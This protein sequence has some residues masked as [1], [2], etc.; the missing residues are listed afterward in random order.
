MEDY[1]SLNKKNTERLINS[2]DEKKHN[3]LVKYRYTI[4]MNMF[5]RF[6][7]KDAS[8]L[9]IGIRDGAFLEFMR[10]HGYNN[11]YGIDIYERSVEIAKVKN[12]ACEVMDVHNMNL[13]KM[14][15][16]IVMSHVLEHCPHPDQVLDSVYY[17]TNER[18]ILFIEVPIEPGEPKPTEKDAH[19][20]NF[21]SLES[22]LDMVE[23][24]WQLLEQFHSPKRVKVVLRRK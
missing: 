20:F 2:T 5:S 15:D 21:H 1:I 22:L 3:R 4:Q 8:V 18:G 10:E 16:L 12:I 19:Y 9:D 11:L 17:H 24:K 23:N 6:V 13:D 14:F 7:D